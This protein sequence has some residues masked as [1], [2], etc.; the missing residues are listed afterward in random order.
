MIVCTVFIYKYIIKITFKKTPLCR[1]VEG[2]YLT[3]K[4]K[5]CKKNV[6]GRYSVYLWLRT[7]LTLKYT[8]YT[9]IS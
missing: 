4:K 7:K 3:K 2:I 1:Y 6:V 8:V 5:L 9:C